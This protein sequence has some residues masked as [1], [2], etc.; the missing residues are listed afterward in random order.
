MHNSRDTGENFYMQLIITQSGY[1]TFK[2]ES[3]LL[4]LRYC[5]FRAMITEQNQNFVKG[6][7]PTGPF[8]SVT[9]N[10]LPLCNLSAYKN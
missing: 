9:L 5:G 7:T 8:L 4:N 1:K 10:Y 6:P 2:A 3:I